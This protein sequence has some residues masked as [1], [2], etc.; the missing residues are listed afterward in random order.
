MRM[1]K[2]SNGYILLF[3]FQGITPPNQWQTQSFLQ[4][5]I[6]RHR[7]NLQLLLGTLPGTP[8]QNTPNH[9][10]DLLDFPQFHHCP[11]N[12]LRPQRTRHRSPHS[13]LVNRLLLL[14]QPSR[15][16]F[17][18]RRQHLHRIRVYHI[19]RDSDRL[20]GI[21]SVRRKKI[22]DFLREFVQFSRSGV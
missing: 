1:K 14:L 10:M 3:A 19:S 21:R 16:P 15:F 22:S 5:K 20:L 7:L 18:R 4:G 8:L 11:P 13:G 12:R 2:R 17:L 9:L 6:L